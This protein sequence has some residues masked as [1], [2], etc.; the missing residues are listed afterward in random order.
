[1]RVKPTSVTSALVSKGILLGASWASGDSLLGQKVLELSHL[2]S[3]LSKLTVID[4]RLFSTGNKRYSL[5]PKKTHRFHTS[6]IPGHTTRHSP[7]RTYTPTQGWRPC[8]RNGRTTSDGGCH[9]RTSSRIRRS[10]TTGGARAT[11]RSSCGTSKRRSRSGHSSSEGPTRLSCRRY[12]ST[13]LGT[14]R[15]AIGRVHDRPSQWV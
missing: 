7:T 11:S 10:T 13:C 3:H 9:S 1:M 2:I 5:T 4:L 6:R 14:P 15:A 12:E 8:W